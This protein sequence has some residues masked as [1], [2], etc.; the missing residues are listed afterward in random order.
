VDILLTAVQNTSSSCER[1]HKELYYD[2]RN[3][4][5]QTVRRFLNPVDEGALTPLADIEA[6]TFDVQL[7]DGAKVRRIQDVLVAVKEKRQTASDDLGDLRTQ[8]ERPAADAEYYR[9]L[10]ARSI[11]LQ[12]RVSEIV[13]VVELH[14]GDDSLMRAISHYK[15][16]DGAIT[17]SAPAEFLDPDEQKVLCEGDGK[18]RVSLY[19]ALLFLRVADAVKAGSLNLK[20]SYKFRSLDDYLIPKDTWDSNREEFLERAELVQASDCLMTLKTL[21]ARLRSGSKFSCPGRH[22]VC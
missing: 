2:G 18:F 19:K 3:E 1:E 5:R 10:E 17:Q 9:A 13:K 11:K 20:L 8:F 6:I 21:A 14:G 15:E 16:K 22:R 4:R 7:P 12:N